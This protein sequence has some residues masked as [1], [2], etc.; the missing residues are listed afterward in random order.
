MKKLILLP[1]F[2]AS[3]ASA[4]EV[5]NTING[6]ITLTDNTIADET[7][8]I[9]GAG[10][11]TMGDYTF[12]TKTVM[13][14][15]D[16]M[17]VNADYTFDGVFQIPYG[18]ITGY[19][20][21][22]IKIAKGKTLTITKFDSSQNYAPNNQRACVVF[23]GDS[24]KNYSEFATV[25]LGLN[26]INAFNKGNKDE[27]WLRYVNMNI[28]TA[29][30]LLR[31]HM[32][33]G[34]SITLQADNIKF[35]G[36]SINIRAPQ[37]ITRTG[38]ENEACYACTA[39]TINLNGYSTSIDMLGANPSNKSAYVDFVIN[40]GENTKAQN[41]LIKEVAQ[42]SAG[43]GSVDMFKLFIN[44]YDFNGGDRIYFGKEGLL[45]QCVYVNGVLLTADMLEKQTSG[46][47]KDTFMVIPEPSTYAMIFGAIALGFVAYR[48]RK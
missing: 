38:P 5:I 1:L 22:N 25:N 46:A 20:D 8:V 32:Y 7:L 6:D 19:T 13:S 21:A 3:L 35:G 18:G 47:Y 36:G 43:L 16:I 2:V 10:T 30:N 48:R 40:F 15:T 28:T 11:M 12:A 34:S 39:G 9:N 4:E 24:T 37:T 26:D 31:V 23:H 42:N 44:D 33:Y 29:A 17:K 27:I 45:Y 14:T 41:L